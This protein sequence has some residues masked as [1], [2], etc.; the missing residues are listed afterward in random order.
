MNP[1]TTRPNDPARRVRPDRL[2]LG[3]GTCRDCGCVIARPEDP[4]RRLRRPVHLEGEC[5]DLVSRPAW[6]AW[7]DALCAEL[8]VLESVPH[9]R[10]IMNWM[11]AERIR[12]ELARGW[13]DLDRETR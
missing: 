13:R 3:V 5:P 9:P 11:R 7:A 2:D 1:T 6:H 10:P 12:D 4:V 8:R